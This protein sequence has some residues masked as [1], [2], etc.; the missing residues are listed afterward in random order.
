MFVLKKKKVRSP[1]EII[2]YTSAFLKYWAGLQDEDGKIL[3][4]NG[5]E[6]LKNAALLHHPQAPDRDEPRTGTVLLQ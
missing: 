5:A 2:C 4:E 3:L 6:A 1:T